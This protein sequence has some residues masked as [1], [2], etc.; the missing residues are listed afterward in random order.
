MVMFYSYYGQASRPVAGT[1]RPLTL[2]TCCW[3]KTSISPSLPGKPSPIAASPNAAF[4]LLPASF[5]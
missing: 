2:T 1:K 4:F 3:F 5:Q